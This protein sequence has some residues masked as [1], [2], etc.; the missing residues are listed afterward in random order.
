MVSNAL[1]YGVIYIVVYT[2]DHQI[3]VHYFGQPIPSSPFVAKV[4]DASKVVV[5]PIACARVGVQSAF[6]SKCI[7]V[8]HAL[9]I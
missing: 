1:S 7:P 2:G 5:A 9:D 4:W 3:D 6:C 8:P